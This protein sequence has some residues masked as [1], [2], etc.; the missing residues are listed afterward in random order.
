MAQVD[1]ARNLYSEALTALDDANKSMLPDGADA[2]TMIGLAQL[3]ATKAA[4][5]ASLAAADASFAVRNE[6]EA[7]SGKLTQSP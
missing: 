1:D 4:A 2:E 3:K 7:L 5:L 6:L